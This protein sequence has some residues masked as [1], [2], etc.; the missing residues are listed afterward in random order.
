VK[1]TKIHVAHFRGF[2]D[3]LEVNLTKKGRNLL[4]Y[5]EN[6]S[7]KSSFYYALRLFLD[8][9]SRNLDFKPNQN[10]FTSQ[11][12]FIKVEI[13]E[14]PE[15]KAQLFEWSNETRET[16]D[17]VILEASKTKGFFDYKGLLRTYFLPLDQESVNV[18]D[19]IVHNLLSTT[20]NNIT[21][22][23]FQEDWKNIQENIP[24]RKSPKSTQIINN[25]I[26][27][28]NRGLAD[29]LNELKELANEILSHFNH[30]TEID[31]QFTGI[32][33][34]EDTKSLLNQK[35][36]LSVKLYKKFIT[37]HHTFL[38]EAR[39]SAIA[40]SI[41]FSSLKLIPESKLK[42]LALDD[43]LIGLDMSNRLPILDILHN[44]FSDYQIFFMTY[45]KV[46]FEMLRLRTNDVEWKYIEFYS[47]SMGENDICTYVANKDYL[48]KAER[49]LI[50]HDYKAAVIYLRTQFEIVLKKCCELNNLSVKYRSDPSKLTSEDFWKP[51]KD[52]GF[53]DEG[54]VRNVET[55]RKFIMNAIS[56]SRI[57]AT[58]KKEL[59][60]AM[61]FV[62]SLKTKIARK[63]SS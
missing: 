20:L 7:G 37:N 60:E 45:D 39:L 5:G 41:Y 6:G 16:N 12:G 8:S 56:H 44:Y 21:S 17:S 43:V 63:I 33:Y 23:T 31:F 15:A 57:I 61:G 24:K 34:D 48:S 62:R 28:F 42:I 51:I 30:S 52:A 32:S 10:I 54:E 27:N 2:Y 13:R 25:R 19:L 50:N 36:M 14:S 49:H 58:E 40:L 29:K 55:Y 53:V 11:E 1:I 47:T 4:I 9:H 38:N 46:W 26:D 18:F 35:I 3:E 22:N 59:Q